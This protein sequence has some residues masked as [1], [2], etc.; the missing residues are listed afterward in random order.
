MITAIPTSYALR[1]AHHQVDLNVLMHVVMMVL[2]H[3]CTSGNRQCDTFFIFC[4]RSLSAGSESGCNNGMVLRSD[5][6]MNDATIDFS[7]GSFLGLNNPV[8]G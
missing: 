1:F 4:L 6:N 7:Q 5:V 8:R 3:A 2:E